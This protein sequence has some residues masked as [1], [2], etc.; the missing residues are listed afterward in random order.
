M[1]LP[2]N[3]GS[4]QQPS[5]PIP[6]KT[7]EI[8]TAAPEN[9]L[10]ELRSGYRSLR[11]LFNILLIGLIVFAGSSVVLMRREN[12]MAQRQLGEHAR[13]IAE[14]QRNIAPK[15]AELHS[16]LEAYSKLHLDFAPIF[17]KYF[18]NTNAPPSQ[19][20]APVSPAPA[21][22]SSASPPRR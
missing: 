19:L 4:E 16:K 12:Q 20:P 3:P 2:E 15:V 22:T 21:P 9:A 6:D 11:S 18:G 17:A 1:P 5:S 7:S 10:D 14:Y 13:Y 8:S